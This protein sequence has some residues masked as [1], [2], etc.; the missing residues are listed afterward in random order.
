MVK[1]IIVN[2]IL[3]YKDKI[4]MYTLCINKFTKLD[5]VMGYYFDCETSE[6]KVYVNEER[7]MHSIWF[8]SKEELEALKH[9][10]ELVKG[11]SR[12]IMNTPG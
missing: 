1:E 3:S 12:I 4:N 2:E 10:L 9:L 6:Y 7:N 5:F 11:Y 8:S